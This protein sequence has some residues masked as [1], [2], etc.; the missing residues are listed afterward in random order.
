MVVYFGSVLPGHGAVRA[1]G[2][3]GSSLYKA[4]IGKRWMIVT[5]GAVAMPVRSRCV[6][7]VR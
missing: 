6:A 3:R 1:L 4:V 5:S 2:L 7:E